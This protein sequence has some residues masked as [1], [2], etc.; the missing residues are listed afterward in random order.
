MKPEFKKYNSIDNFSL[1]LVNKYSK[2]SDLKD[3]TWVSLEKVHGANYSITIYNNTIE[4][5]KRTSY[6][7]NDKSFYNHGEIDN[8]YK[9]NFLQIYNII[10]NELNLNNNTLIVRLYGEIFGGLYPGVKNKYKKIQ[11]GVFYTNEIEF[12]VYDIE[13]N[14]KSINDNNRCKYCESSGVPYLKQLKKG[15]LDELYTDFDPNLFES[16]IYSYYNLPKIENN[17]AEGVVFKPL[18]PAFLYNGSHAIIKYKSSKFRET[19]ISDHIKEIINQD[20]D[21]KENINPIILELFNILKYKITTNRKN[22]V[23][24]KYSEDHFKHENQL[25]MFVINDAFDEFFN[26]LKLLDDNIKEDTKTSYHD[27]F[28]THKFKKELI[29]KLLNVNYI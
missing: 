22:N 15:T 29:K 4:Y 25:K 20:K 17:I 8:K 28:N 18:E 1:A 21:V 16:T 3:A 5:G 6:L 26:E 24:S 27:I 10:K 14:N 9:N 13:I 2:I 11:D 7:G 19:N 23:I 12:L